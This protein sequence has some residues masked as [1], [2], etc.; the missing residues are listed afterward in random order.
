M[1]FFSKA[2]LAAMEPSSFYKNPLN[3][4]GPNALH[5]APCSKGIYD[6]QIEEI[7]K[8]KSPLLQNQM[9]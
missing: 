9:D 5:P 4:E 8:N 3:Y 1:I 6:P 7:A 2:K